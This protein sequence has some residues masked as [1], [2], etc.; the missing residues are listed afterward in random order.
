[1]KLPEREALGKIGYD[2]YGEAAGWK[3]FRGDPMP[4]WDELPSHIRRYWCHAAIAIS[5]HILEG[6]PQQLALSAQEN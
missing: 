4:S 1:M 6:A 5:V 3:N 2:A